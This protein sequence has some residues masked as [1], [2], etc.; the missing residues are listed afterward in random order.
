MRHAGLEAIVEPE[1]DKV[2]IQ[3]SIPEITGISR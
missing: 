2:M 3:K 1:L